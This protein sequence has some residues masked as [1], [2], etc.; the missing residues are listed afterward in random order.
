[1]AV[2]A[3]ALLLFAA[4][5]GGSLAAPTLV[6]QPTV[7]GATSTPAPT[8][9][10][11]PTSVPLLYAV[12]A[13]D[14]LGAIAEQFGVSVEDLAAANGI[15]DVTSLQVGDVLTIPGV[16]VTPAPAR[17][18][19]PV[20]TSADSPIGIHMAMPV[21]GA[22][23]T[24]D[25]EQMPNATRE[26]RYGI[27]EGVDFFTGYACV[28]VPINTPA[29]APAAGVVIRADK[30]YRPLTQR[31]IEELEA[32]SAAQGYTDAGALDKFR[33]RQVWIDHGG[34]IVTRY[35]HLAGIPLDLQVGTHVK[36]GDLVGYI[37]DSGTPESA[38][39]PEFEIHLH[40]EIRVGDSYL[41]AGLGPLETRNIYERVFGLPLSETI[42]V[43]PDIPEP[44]P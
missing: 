11:A 35:A 20:T 12:Q 28:D 37:G 14:T 6:P 38:S 27:H 24:P 9:T 15:E 16:F 31:E 10:S 1:V 44:T 18:P 42:P 30:D 25:D 5:D 43:P 22:C 17:T 41:G 29:L 13:G 21:A 23:L 8:A 34:G 2:L 33:G 32:R 40:F 7:G 36:Q 3:A 19:P 4:C 26:Y 39:N